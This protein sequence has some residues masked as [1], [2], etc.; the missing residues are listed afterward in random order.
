M[1]NSGRHLPGVELSRVESE[2]NNHIE[3]PKVTCEWNEMLKDHPCPP[4]INR[5]DTFEETA[6]FHTNALEKLWIIYMFN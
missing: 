1:G 6:A 3:T 4:F 5:D 2:R